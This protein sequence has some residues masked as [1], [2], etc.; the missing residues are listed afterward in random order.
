MAEWFDDITLQW[1]SSE[2][3]Q[4]NPIEA[5]EEILPPEPVE[6][7]SAP[8]WQ[9]VNFNFTTGG[10]SAPPFGNVPFQWF[11][12]LSAV[13]NLGA[14]VTGETNYQETTYSEIKNR[15]IYALGYANPG[16]QIL[17]GK[18]V[19]AGIRDL[20]GH[21]YGYVQSADLWALILGVL[22]FESGEIDL[23]AWISGWAEVDLGGIVFDIPPA[24]LVA[25]ITAFHPRDLSAYIKA[26]YE[27]DL[28]AMIGATLQEPLDL[29]AFI[30]GLSL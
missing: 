17:K 2:T 18:T 25:T 30:S 29:T 6:D 28:P 24:D 7:Y 10:Y 20:G 8:S 26:W 1:Y 19:Y 27:K 12:T 5:D 3:E 4:W 22:P 21:L 9:D 14:S 11:S 15:N 23:P 16:W 13:M